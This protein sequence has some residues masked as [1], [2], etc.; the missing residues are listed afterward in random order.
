MN[1]AS[2]DHVI[3]F[4]APPGDSGVVHMRTYSL[5][6]RKQ[7]A[8]DGASPVPKARLVLSAPSMDFT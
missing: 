3:T 7:T 5:H 4:T 2:L 8:S 1:L 6:L